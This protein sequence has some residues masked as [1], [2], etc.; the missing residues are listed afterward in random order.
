MKIILFWGIFILESVLVYFAI[1]YKD[2]IGHTLDA[3]KRSLWVSIPLLFLGV[4]VVYEN[5]IKIVK[6]FN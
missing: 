5:V 1:H 4:V 2:V 6:Y 3:S